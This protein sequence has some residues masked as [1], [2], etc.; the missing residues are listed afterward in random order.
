MFFGRDDDKRELLRRLD[1]HRFV[2]VVGVSGCGKSSLIR[3]GIIASLKAGFLLGSRDKS[4]E[5]A[6][7]RGVWHCLK[8]RPGNMAL[9]ELAG[10]L[11]ALPRTTAGE[12]SEAL[13]E[14]AIWKTLKRSPFGLAEVIR[15]AD[16]GPADNVFLLIDQFEEIFTMSGPESRVMDEGRE[17]VRLLL[18]A[19]R[20]DDLPLHL[21]LTMRTDYLGD[22]AAL[23]DLAEAINSSLYLLPQMDRIGLEEAIR[24][25]P[26]D[27]NGAVS[28]ALVNRLLNDANNQADYLPVLQHALMRLWDAL[29]GDSSGRKELDIE[30]Y[31]SESLGTL[32]DALNN[33]L[34]ELFGSLSP[35]QQTI[36]ETIFREIT[37]VDTNRRLV[38]RPTAFARIVSRCRPA[39]EDEVKLVID[40]FRAPGCSFLT[41]TAG[42]Q[43]GAEDMIDASHEALLRQWKRNLD[44]ARK[45]GRDRQIEQRLN[46]A[47]GRWSD[48]NKDSSILYRGLPLDE[49]NQWWGRHPDQISQSAREF[50]VESRAQHESQRMANLDLETG[51]GGEGVAKPGGTIYLA[52]FHLADPDKTKRLQ[53]VLTE[54]GFQ[55]RAAK[56][57]KEGAD[58]AP[59]RESLDDIAIAD[60]VLL[61]AA[62]ETDQD[63]VFQAERDHALHLQKR[64]ARVSFATGSEAAQR[65]GS[66]AERV[67]VID[68]EFSDSSVTSMLNALHEDYGRLSEHIRLHSRASDW[69]SRGRDRSFLLRGSEL[70]QAQEWLR[71]ADAE[72]RITPTALQRKFVEQ[73]E[74]LH[75][76]RRLSA[77]ASVGVLLVLITVTGLIRVQREAE[78]RQREALAKEKEAEADAR[79]KEARLAEK[80]KEILNEQARRSVRRYERA[81]KLLNEEEKTEPRARALALGE[82]G[83]ALVFNRANTKAAELACSLLLSPRLWALPLTPPLRNRPSSSATIVCANFAPDS[84]K[85][86]KIVAVANDGYL[87]TWEVGKTLEPERYSLLA[88]EQLE[89]VGSARGGKFGSGSSFSPDGRNLC[90]ISAGTASPDP[91][92]GTPAT[93]DAASPSSSSAP[94]VNVTLYSWD[95]THYVP[96]GPVMKLAP[97]PYRNF[98][99]TADSRIV[100]ITYT[101]RERNEQSGK[102]F[103]VDESRQTWREAPA[104]FLG[105]DSKAVSAVSFDT[106]SKMAATASLQGEIH[107]WMR[108]KTDPSLWTLT[109]DAPV[110]LGSKPYY[111]TFAP[112]DRNLVASPM[113]KMPLFVR[114]GKSVEG[115]GNLP[116]EQDL[117]M[118]YT[119]GPVQKGGGLTAI[120]ATGRVYLTPADAGEK[121]DRLSEPIPS[122]GIGSALQFSPDGHRLLVLSGL[123]TASMDTIQVWDIHRLK[124]IAP[125]ST[126]AKL[127]EVKVDKPAPPWLADLAYVVGGRGRDVSEFDD[128]QFPSFKSVTRPGDKDIY[129][130]VWDRFFGDGAE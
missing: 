85:G 4:G 98:T 14:E 108:D 27:S 10:A 90:L 112:G 100:V 37:T 17:F 102:A 71:R 36:A 119:Y 15:G 97:N 2:A 123:T 94:L 42:Q 54:C 23:P 57:G 39:S 68:Q 16:L 92:Q 49:A 56:L 106:E 60:G 101:V 18:E 104:D 50:V 78:I 125:E 64:V 126:T 51:L 31:E 93:G 34:E 20:D 67:I 96:K 58:D 22:C 9:R 91:A 128:N 41:A 55:I 19:M 130:A 79:L 32:G 118:R 76:R 21:V 24:L 13:S 99:W 5:G 3:A 61:Y 114:G 29:P 116:Y 40:K 82:L 95:G 53:G 121:V 26:E 115:G 77:I 86:D 63:S 45:E 1:S 127:R 7:R 75:R 38:R 47:A 109:S 66:P 65:A 103:I 8:M 124:K 35:V 48:L 89:A 69:N 11:R 28:D 46:D 122:P 117:W 43:V 74:I 81:A 59:R 33:H 120:V 30:Q 70:K 80:E 105:L 87:L 12:D 52:G 88:K 73:S 107:W 44:W 84:T 6:A 113:Q 110:E 72:R 62:G 129:Q 25:P 83:S 111:L